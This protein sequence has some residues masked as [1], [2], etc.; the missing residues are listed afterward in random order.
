[1]AAT[2][3]F[4]G[5]RMLERIV[6][7][8]CE[9]RILMTNPEVADLRTK[10]EE[11]AEG[12]IPTNIRMNLAYL[13]RV[14][15]K[16]ESVRYYYGTPTV[17]AVATTDRMLLNPY[18]YQIEAFRCF[19]LTIHKTLNPHEDIF[20]QYIRHHFQEPWECAME[21]SLDEWGMLE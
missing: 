21:I 19:S 1:M 18:P 15:V 5:R 17:F 14:G 16:R 7:S 4:D 12:E 8:N 6:Q 11:R 10:Q 2:K 9:L 3:L 13:K 20:H